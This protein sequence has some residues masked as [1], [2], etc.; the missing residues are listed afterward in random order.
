MAI[1]DSLGSFDVA[2]DNSASNNN[3]TKTQQS[4]RKEIFIVD[5]VR[6]PLVVPPRASAFAC[7]ALD[8]GGQ[9]V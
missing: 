5:F 9:P 2:M 4:A 1:G 3:P 8:R 6:G 7:L